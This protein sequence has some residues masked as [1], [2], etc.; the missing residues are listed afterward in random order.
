MDIAGTDESRY[1]E[2]T[3]HGANGTT[4]KAPMSKE[5][6]ERELA[7]L[8]QTIRRAEATLAEARDRALKLT[9][10]IEVVQEYGKREG[11]LPHA[12]REQEAKPNG[13]I[14]SKVP[15]GGMSGRAVRECVEILRAQNRRIPTDRLLE[16]LQERGIRIGGDKPRNSLSGY[17]SRTPEVDSDRSAGGWGLKEWSASTNEE[18]G[19]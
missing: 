10:Y 13:T 7:A 18:L 4:E 11:D 14:G 15:K 19:L 1:N 12:A 16:M 3:S 17:L 2:Q 5:R 6:A 9:H 8:Q